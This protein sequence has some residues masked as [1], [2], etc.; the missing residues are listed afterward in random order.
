[1][2]SSIGIRSGVPK[3]AQVEENT[4]RF[5]PFS[6]IALEKI[7]AAVHVVL[8]ILVRIQHGFGH[9][10]I[11]RE[12]HDCIRTGCLDRERNRFRIKSDRLG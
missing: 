1:M 11:G 3:V 6:I 8:K 12:M 5:T 7:Q 10:R 9:E 2:L 4:M